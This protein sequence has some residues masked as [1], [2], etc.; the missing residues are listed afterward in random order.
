[1]TAGGAPRGFGHPCPKH[2][3][4]MANIV[5]QSIELDFDGDEIVI[6]RH[7]LPDA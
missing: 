5:N 3:A 2:P 6:D 4:G 7:D 1:M